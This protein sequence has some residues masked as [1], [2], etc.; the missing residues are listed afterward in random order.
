MKN[1]FIIILSVSIFFN[2]LQAE[3]LLIQSQNIKLDKDKEISI[4]QNEVFV[5]TDK[6]HSIESDFAE[7]NKKIGLVKFSGNI[8]LT[9]NKGTEISAIEDEYNE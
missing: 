9:D 4:F 7:Y 8:K 6:N 1:N 2:S 5:Q 3:N